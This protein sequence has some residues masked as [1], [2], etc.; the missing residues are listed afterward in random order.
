MLLPILLCPVIQWRTQG[1]GRGGGGM[2]AKVLIKYCVFGKVAYHR[3]GPGGEAKSRWANFGFFLP[4][5]VI[6]F[7]IIHHQIILRL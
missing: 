3:R 4:L 5:L 7:D 2:L 1:L 6:I